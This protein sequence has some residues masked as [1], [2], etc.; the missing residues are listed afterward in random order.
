MSQ[1]TELTDSISSWPGI[2]VH[3]HRFDGQEFRVRRAEVGHM[4]E[5]GTIDIPFPRAIRDVLLA[6]GLA[7]KHHWVP[8]SGWVTFRIRSDAEMKHGLWLMRLSYI[9]YAIRIVP[10]PEQFLEQQRPML[11]L[12]PKLR[13]LLDQM[14]WKPDFPREAF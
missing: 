9:R 4:H 3:P 12:N 2:S 13:S 14:I 7:T 5:G 6:E 10:D 8:D 11:Q 1:T